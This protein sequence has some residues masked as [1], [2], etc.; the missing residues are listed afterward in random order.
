MDRNR[1]T[2]W[3]IAQD[4]F[5]ASFMGVRYL[6]SENPDLDNMKYE[7]I[8]PFGKV[9]LYKNVKEADVARFYENTVSEESLRKLCTGKKRKKNRERILENY[10]VTEDGADISDLSELTDILEEQKKSAVTL[11]AIEKDSH[12]TGNVSAQADG[13]VMCMIPWEKGWTVAV[14]GEKVQTQKGDLGFLA[15]RVDKGEHQLELT[16]QVPGL[17]AGMAASAVC[18]FIYISIC[19]Y[20]SRKKKRNL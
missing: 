5:F 11:D 3:P 10:L 13:Y 6:I 15:F 18:W 17:K 8:H 12:L 2:F 7:L 19:L 14:D 9:F 1:Y 4:T 20:Q 16:Y